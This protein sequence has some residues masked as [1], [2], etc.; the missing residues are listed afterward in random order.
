M[1]ETLMIGVAAYGPQ[2]AHFWKS[3]AMTTGSL[4]QYDIELRGMIVAGSMAT[5]QNRNA[6]VTNFLKGSA[7]W[8]LWIDCDNVIPLG[9][10]RRLLDTGKTF[11][12]GL[13]YL[14]QQGS[15]P[16]AYRSIGNGYYKPI[17]NWTRGEIVPIDMAGMGAT[18]THRSVFEDIQKQCEVVKRKDGSLFVLHKSEIKGELPLEFSPREA[19]AVNGMYQVP[20][21]KAQPDDIRDWPFFRLEYGRT[22]DL[23]FYELAAKSGHPAFVDTS[24]ECEHWGMMDYGGANYR[25]EQ[26]EEPE[27]RVTEWILK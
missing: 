18:L 8:L 6:V 4:H 9:G 22:E 26:A 15:K 14:K 27:A 5:D 7:E 17:E 12:T 2:P 20:V 24:V 16:V 23:A 13:Y 21:K 11:V 19:R 10:V 25:R 1:A 3:L